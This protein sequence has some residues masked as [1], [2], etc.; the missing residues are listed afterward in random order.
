MPPL[1]LMLAMRAG[2]GPAW[3][4]DGAVRAEMTDDDWK[5]LALFEKVLW[6]TASLTTSLWFGIT[7]LVFTALIWAAAAQASTSPSVPAAGRVS[8]QIATLVLLSLGFILMG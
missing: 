6:A 5:A 7:V 8:S 4:D 2:R 1:A 3:K